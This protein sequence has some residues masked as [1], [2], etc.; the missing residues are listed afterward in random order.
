VEVHAYLAQRR[1]RCCG[2]V[3]RGVAILNDMVYVGT[4]DAHLV[5]LDIKSGIVRWDSEWRTEVGP[6]NHRSTASA[7]GQN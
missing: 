2:P 4:Y 7:A 6:L 1:S 5:A 3:N